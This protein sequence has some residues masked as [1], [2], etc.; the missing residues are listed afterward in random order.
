MKYFYQRNF[1]ESICFTPE[2][3]THGNPI[4][5]HVH[6]VKPVDYAI[7][8]IIEAWVRDEKI[9]ISFAKMSHRKMKAQETRTSFLLSA[10][11][12]PEEL[13]KYDP[14]KEIYNAISLSGDPLIS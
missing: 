11:N 12:M 8:S 9:M 6:E 3:E 14:V 1:K 13:D 5:V 7:P 10:E 2:R 4:I